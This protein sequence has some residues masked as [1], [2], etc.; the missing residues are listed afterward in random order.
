VFRQGSVAEAVWDR[1]TTWD[2]GKG[3]MLLNSRT[4]RHG[5][6]ARTDRDRS[7]LEYRT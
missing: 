4:Y 2:R 7:D 3:Y 5:P 1:G 6:R